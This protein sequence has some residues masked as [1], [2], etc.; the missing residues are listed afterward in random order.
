M[1]VLRVSRTFSEPQTRVCLI[2]FHTPSSPL[3][4]H[5]QQAVQI[6]ETAGPQPVVYGE[7]MHPDGDGPE[8]R[9]TVII[10]GHYDVQPEDPVEE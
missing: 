10:Y 2:H 1:A 9:P 5:T 8:K 3:R 7:F 6:I 4:H